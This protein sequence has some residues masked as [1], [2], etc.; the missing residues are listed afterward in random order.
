M[1]FNQPHL[2]LEK[3]WGR[4]ILLLSAFLDTLLTKPSREKSIAEFCSAYITR[5]HYNISKFIPKAKRHVILEWLD[6]SSRELN[7]LCRPTNLEHAVIELFSQRQPEIPYVIVL[8]EYAILDYTNTEN[9]P[10]SNY[11]QY[12]AW[13]LYNNSSFA[14]KKRYHDLISKILFFFQVL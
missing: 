1:V 7:H 14:P 2:K 6:Q 10:I 3:E 9:L 11:I 4:M 12:I 13:L 5:D 8:L